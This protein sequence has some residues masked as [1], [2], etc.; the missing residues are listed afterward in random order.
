[1]LELPR[2][3]QLKLV[4]SEASTADQPTSK[5]SDDLPTASVAATSASRERHRA[6][7]PW[8]AFFT[9]RQFWAFYLNFFASGF[10]TFV[11]L[12]WMP[13]Y[14]SDQFGVKLADI[15]FFTAAPYI[16]Q[17]VCTVI[18]GTLSQRLIASKT[19]SPMA[20]CTLM[21]MIGARKCMPGINAHSTLSSISPMFSPPAF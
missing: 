5:G 8:R 14:F 10:G 4:E 13:T 16:F 9:D 12:A 19:L 3:R 20:T 6:P 18:A 7:I 11:L 21:Q 17:A 2:L 1:V 15:G